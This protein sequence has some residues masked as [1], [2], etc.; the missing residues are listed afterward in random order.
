ME[1]LTSR[2]RQQAHG[3][4]LIDSEILIFSRKDAKAQRTRGKSLAASRLCVSNSPESG[5][6]ADGA[7]NLDLK[8]AE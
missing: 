1:V 7:D 5:N 2:E 4:R 6:L 8:E 3:P